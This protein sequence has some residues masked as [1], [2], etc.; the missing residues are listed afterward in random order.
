MIKASI[1]AVPGLI[2]AFLILTAVLAGLTV[3][4]ARK[5]GR[6]ILLPALLATSIAGIL[7]VTLLPG[8]AGVEAGQCDSGLPV[9]LLT[10][11]SSLLNMGLFIPGAAISV[12]LFRRPATTIASFIIL[13]GLVEFIQAVTP[14]GRSCSAGDLAANATGALTGAALAVASL[15][16]RRRPRPL[17]R[18]GRDLIWGAGLAAV[19]AV[20]LAGAFNSR[21]HAVDVVSADDHRQAVIDSGDGSDQWLA[22]AAEDLFGKGT[23]I[24]Q[25]GAEKDGLLLKVTATTNRGSISGWWPERTLEQAWATDNHGERGKLSKTQAA[26]V[27]KAFADKYVRDSVMGSDQVT[28]PIGGDADAAYLVTFRR[29]RQGVL[30]PMRLD[31]TV[32]RAGRIIGFTS[33]TVKDPALPQAAVTKSAA[34]EQAAKT[35][36]GKATNAQLMAKKVGG[37]WRPLW[38]VG[39]NNTDVWLDAV[40][41]AKTTP[42]K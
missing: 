1:S 25:T 3:L 4:A 27:A 9:H 2:A 42:D 34:L 38:L 12:L 19:G 37:Q 33:K 18:L 29:Y 30:M 39:A 26:Q 6:P 28:R 14:L 8:T 20:A 16:T 17:R 41:G 11:S 40:T 36:G 7:T 24:Q 15:R 13:S 21:V 32:T 31:F 22:A 5:L 35:A 23:E 10:S